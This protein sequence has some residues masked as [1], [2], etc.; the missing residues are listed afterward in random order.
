MALEHVQGFYLS[1]REKWKLF[2]KQH[3]YPDLMH[4][5][6]RLGNVG[7]VVFSAAFN[8]SVWNAPVVKKERSL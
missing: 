7:Y 4:H 2:S 5:R 8:H 6:R 1:V 3:V